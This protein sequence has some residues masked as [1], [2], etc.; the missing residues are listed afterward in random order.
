MVSLREYY[1]SPTPEAM[2]AKL[3]SIRAFEAV[4]VPLSPTDEGAFVPNWDDRMF[5]E[6]YPFG[7]AIIKDIASMVGVPR[8]PST[9]CNFYRAQTGIAYI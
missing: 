4:K 7:V 8:R 1:E 6:D 5:T 3:K 2:T 9:R